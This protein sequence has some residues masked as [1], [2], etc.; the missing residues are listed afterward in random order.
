MGFDNKQ[1]SGILLT[2]IHNKLNF[3]IH[4]DNRLKKIRL[5]AEEPIKK[6]ICQTSLG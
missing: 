4:V 2:V 3:I 5:N 6:N 1:L